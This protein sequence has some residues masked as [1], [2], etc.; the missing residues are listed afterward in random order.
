MMA[1]AIQGSKFKAQGW[2]WAEI[3]FPSLEGGALPGGTKRKVESG[4][5]FSPRFKVSFRD[6]LLL[7]KIFKRHDQHPKTFPIFRT[8]MFMVHLMG[9]S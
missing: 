4:R 3:K 2:F 8:E 1:I 6:M 5:D 7:P 9:P